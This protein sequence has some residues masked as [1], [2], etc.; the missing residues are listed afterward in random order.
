MIKT[1]VDTSQKRILTLPRFPEKLTRTQFY[2]LAYRFMYLSR[3]MD[4]KL[5]ELFRKGYV[6]GTVTLS[7]GTEATS[8]GM[9][10]P[11]RPGHDVLSLLHRDLGAHL[12]QGVTLLSLMCQ[13]IANDKSPT[14]GREGNV[15]HGNA[16]MRRLP[17]ISHLGD[18]LSL[19][20]GAV[21][22]ARRNGED[23]MGLAIVGDGGSSTGDFHES[24][25]IASV[26]RIPV[27]F[28]IENNHYAYST[29]TRFQYNCKQ[30]SDRAA[31]YG[32][33]G[34][35]IDGTDAWEVY[36]TV[37]NALETMAHDSMPRL[38][39][40]MTLRLEGHAAY[41]KAEYV[42]QEERQQW[43]KREPIMRARIA[44]G[45]CGFSEE[46]IAALEAEVVDEVNATAREALQYG[47]PSPQVH[48]GP[49]YAPPEERISLPPLRFEHARNLNA[50]N[51]ALDY[52][53]QHFPS[54]CLF[55]QDIG[56]YGSAFK[57]C[58]G[59]YEKYGAERVMD[60]PLAESATTGLCLGAS[61]TGV[62]PI[63]EFQFADFATE[64]VTQL[65]LNAGTWY[66]RTGRPARILF[67]LPCGGGITLGAFHSGEF[68]GLWTR[69]PGLKIFYPVTPQEMFE[70]IVAGF[71]DPNPC[72]VFEHK[73]LYGGRQETI[74]FN[75]D[76]T[77]VCRPRKYTEGDALT[78]IAFGAMVE[79]V[80]AVVEKHNYSVE[81]WNPFILNPLHL[82]A[83]IE[84]VRRTGRLLVVQES[85]ETAGMGDRII[86][87]V[88]RKAFDAL[89]SAPR[90]V[91]AP[92]APVPF[93]KELESSHIP[94]SAKIDQEIAMMMGATS[95]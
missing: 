72:L 1:A 92:D 28:L 59:L 9:S 68:D 64:A 90:L 94:D 29:P 14:H 32:I 70:A 34:Q 46:M 80:R 33:E 85:G 73:L 87:L 52:I 21:F 16:A 45:G 31:G 17:M 49:V 56:V 69:F 83:L 24:L 75:G 12:V 30:L 42:S 25:N 63:M 7:A 22:G 4:E 76:Y 40:C 61:Q 57:S 91:G 62:L 86:S 53:M 51:A 79:T 15:H 54:A 23:A 10:F 89:S 93:A 55:G 6:K 71:M 13:F 58:R 38:V 27:L 67:R 5:K 35:T 77:A 78:I 81:V 50:V 3:Q 2:P 47:R 20:V 66:F 8:I 44:L 11:F 84:S 36:T 65:G 41:D 95:E 19:A 82:D 26:R 43:L 39:E 18:M 74:E 60:M 48:L 37:C 88:C